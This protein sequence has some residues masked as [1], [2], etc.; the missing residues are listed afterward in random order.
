MKL[1]EGDLWEYPANYRI[2]TTNGTVKRNGHTV[3]GRGC[4]LEATRK[5]PDITRL[6]GA[7]IS[8][9]GLHVHLFEG[10]NLIAFP[11]KYQW[12][13]KAHP[14]LIR[15]SVGELLDLI[16]VHRLHHATLVMPRA[17]CGN[18][19]LMWDE[20]EP[21]LKPLPDNVIVIDFPRRG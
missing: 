5:Y 15:Q 12:M 9:E 2:I 10:W 16:K 20:V 1:T 3:M 7:A 14:A 11:V 8:R 4:A 18:G 13:E 19:R 6:L 21:L 17:G